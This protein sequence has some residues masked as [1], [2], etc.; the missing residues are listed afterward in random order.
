VTE[1]PLEQGLSVNHLSNFPEATE[2]EKH[3]LNPFLDTEY[4]NKLLDDLFE[5]KA[6]LNQ[7]LVEMETQETPF[8]ATPGSGSRSSSI[9]TI[10]SR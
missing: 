5:Q 10:W 2:N 6:F 3:S 1:E 7:I 8:F 9:A 4:R